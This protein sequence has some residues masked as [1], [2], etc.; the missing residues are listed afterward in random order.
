MGKY[1]D[2]INRLKGVAILLVLLG[3]SV[4]F[5]PVNLMEVNWCKT[6][7]NYIYIFHMPLFF[8]I[9]GFLYKY[10]DNYKIY[11]LSK[12]KRLL[13]PYV[14]FNIANLLLRHSFPQFINRN[15][16]LGRDIYDIL[17]SGGEYWFLY[18]LFMIFLIFPII[19]KKIDSKI[20]C[21]IILIILVILRSL[22]LT[23]I[24]RVDELVKN[25]FYF[26]LGYKIKNIY[27]LKYKKIIKNKYFILCSTIIFITIG[28]IPK[29]II[30]LIVG[31]LS[32]CILAYNI[33]MILPYNNI[34]KF[35]SYCGTYSLQLYLLNG[36]IL[37]PARI[38]I[39]KILS[40]SN[41]I[42]IVSSIFIIN[43]VVGLIVI[44]YIINK[45]KVLSYM[46]GI[47]VKYRRI[48]N[49]LIIN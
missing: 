26:I 8:I 18:T 24:F 44:K 27:N 43:I 20:N 10:K 22:D 29:N 6:M 11:I 38:I 16:T 1:Y 25:I 2:E 49:E 32:G 45:S 5:T 39:V 19:E 28:I 4:I 47:N 23:Y 17:L 12:V 34:N 21:I 48:K 9:S 33:V 37:V 46:C 14:I 36:F 35:L 41:P 13:I 40:I 7:Y 3:H 30:T 15:N 42:I 31:A